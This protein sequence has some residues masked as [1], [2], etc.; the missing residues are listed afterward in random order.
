M[1][2]GYVRIVG[3]NHLKMDIQSAENP[4]ET[5]SAIAFSQ[6]QH[7]DAILRKKTF[8]ACYAVEEN[9]FNGNISLQMNVKDMKVTNNE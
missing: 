6:A 1:D 7:F 5:F 2:K 8:S 4:K 9:E 3:N